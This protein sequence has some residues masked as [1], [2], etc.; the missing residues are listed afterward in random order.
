MATDGRHAEV[1]FGTDWA[2]DAQRR[3]FTINALYADANGRLHDFTGGRADLAAGIVRFIGD[4]ERRVAEDYLRV[5]RFFRF[6]ARFA[7]A[8]PMPQ[9]W[10][11]VPRQR[12]GWIACRASGCATSC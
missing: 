11:P 5:L 9:R 1:M 8:P 2:E 12:I 3:D 6:H 10:P 4:A 7:G